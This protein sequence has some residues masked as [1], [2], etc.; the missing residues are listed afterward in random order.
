MSVVVLGFPEHSYNSDDL[1]VCTVRIHCM[2]QEIHR[3]LNLENSGNGFETIPVNNSTIELLVDGVGA[4]SGRP[5]NEYLSHLL[6]RP[7]F[8]DGLIMQHNADGEMVSLVD[9]EHTLDYWQ[10][11]DC[12]ALREL[13]ETETQA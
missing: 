9:S 7:V 1:E 5:R 4:V 10:K 12:K 8:G 13:L 2:L 11:D 6:E 3:F